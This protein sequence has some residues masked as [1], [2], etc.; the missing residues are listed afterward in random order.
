MATQNNK[1][2]AEVGRAVGPGPVTEQ[3][4]VQLLFNTRVKDLPLGFYTSVELG[5]YYIYV[6]TLHSEPPE[7]Y[8]E[9]KERCGRRTVVKIKDPNPELTVGELITQAKNLI[10]MTINHNCSRL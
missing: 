5:D 3:G 1:G 8:V 4:L 2:P 6:W 9:K 10:E 7:V